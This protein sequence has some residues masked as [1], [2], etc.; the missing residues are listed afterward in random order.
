[1]MMERERRR[2]LSRVQVQGCH[3]G[4]SCVWQ[5]FTVS[6]MLFSTY[7]RILE[8]TI[9]RIKFHALATQKYTVSVAHATTTSAVGYV[10]RIDNVLVAVRPRLRPVETNSDW[11]HPQPRARLLIYHVRNYF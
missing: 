7:D 10:F 2:S 9:C 11:H 1:M 6:T 3:G 4:F 8:H 5:Y